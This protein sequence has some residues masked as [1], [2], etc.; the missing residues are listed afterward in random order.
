MTSLQG[1]L[2]NV[3]ASTGLLPH[4]SPYASALA[5]QSPSCGMTMPPG[6]YT[7]QPLAINMPISRPQGIGSF[8]SEEA[9]FAS[10]NPIHPSSG[11]YPGLNAPNPSPSAGGN[12]FG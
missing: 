3:S 10:L 11:R 5:L 1:A 8:R 12:P 6:A 7:G 4:S 2:A 9:A